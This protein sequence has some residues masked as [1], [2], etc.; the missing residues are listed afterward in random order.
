VQNAAY[1]QPQSPAT[2]NA[3]GAVNYGNTYTR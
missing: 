3:G 1:A 2:Y